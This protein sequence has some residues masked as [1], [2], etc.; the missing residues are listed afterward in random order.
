LS[1]QVTDQGTI[2][3]INGNILTIS[4][5]VSDN[6]EGCGIKFLCS[7][8][9]GEDKVIKIEN[10]IDGKVGDMVEVSEA[11]NVLLILSLIQ[12]GIPLIGFLS[13]IFISYNLE[14]G[15]NPIEL[16][17]FIC[18]LI[19]LGI[20]GGISYLI[21]KWIAKKPDKLCNISKI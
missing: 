7:P 10:T 21:F 19:G 2:T 4:I 17:Q 1:N 16:F 3:K 14:F 9:S 5:K 18:G 12:Y 20:A 11:S 13:G 8:K 15:F 6:C